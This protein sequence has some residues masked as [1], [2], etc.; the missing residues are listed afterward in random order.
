MFNMFANIDLNVHKFTYMYIFSHTSEL[1]YKQVQH[2]LHC[3]ATSLRRS[4]C[5][6][7]VV[8]HSPMIA[9]SFAIV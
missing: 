4:S 2:I 6:G 3:I 5:Q 8:G 7:D 1:C 9:M